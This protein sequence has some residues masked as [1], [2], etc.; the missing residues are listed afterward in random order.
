M[1]AFDIEGDDRR[2][3]LR[4]QTLFGEIVTIERNVDEADIFGQTEQFAQAP[5]D[6][7]AAAVNADQRRIFRQVWTN[8]LGQLATLRLGVG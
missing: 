5:G 8:E 7:R 1:A 2:L 4:V 6:P 3:A